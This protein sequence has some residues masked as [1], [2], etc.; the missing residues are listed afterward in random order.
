MKNRK[1]YITLISVLLVSAAGVMISLSI[2]LLGNASSRT[3]FALQQSN[4]ARALSNACVEKALQQI[5]A[6]NFTGSGNITEGFG[7]CTF[8][9]TSQGGENRTIDAVGN[10]DGRVRKARVMIND[11]IPQINISSWQEVAD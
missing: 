6:S 4:Q 7:V 3:S 8:T 9:V 2:I 10:V 5:M 11:I 1:G